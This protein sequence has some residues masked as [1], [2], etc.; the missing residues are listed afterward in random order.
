MVNKDVLSLWIP[1]W[2]TEQLVFEER[3]VMKACT[4][5]YTMFLMSPTQN[6]GSFYKM[7]TY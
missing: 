4:I 2:N 3:E 5:L 7:E 1:G 6:T